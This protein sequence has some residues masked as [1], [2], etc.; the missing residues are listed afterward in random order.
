MLA[1]DTTHKWRKAE[2]T[3]NDAWQKRTHTHTHHGLEVRLCVRAYSLYDGRFV[4][5]LIMTLPR[6]KTHTNKTTNKNNTH[7]LIHIIIQENS[8]WRTPTQC[9]Q[10]LLYKKWNAT[11]IK[12]YRINSDGLKALGYRVRIPLDGS[13]MYKDISRTFKRR[14]IFASSSPQ[15][16][17][18][19][20]YQPKK[21]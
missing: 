18:L 13:R 3:S 15:I 14:T 9:L 2:R 16:H 6:E 5:V 19:K 11:V 17:V 10:R 4:Y 7:H 12:L 21:A 8:V 1:P 20:I